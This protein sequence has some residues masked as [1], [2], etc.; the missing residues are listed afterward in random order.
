M[1]KIK[2]SDFVGL[3]F[4]KIEVSD[5]QA[6][7]HFWASDNKQFIMFHEQDCCENVYLEDVDGEFDFLIGTPI[8]CAEEVTKDLSE[9]AVIDPHKYDSATWTFYHLNTKNGY[10]TL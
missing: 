4:I 8:L 2:V 3:T 7:V 6:Q 10:V 9:M 5:D 1:N